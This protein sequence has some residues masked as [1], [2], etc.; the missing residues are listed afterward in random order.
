VHFA[1]DQQGMHKI[2]ARLLPVA[3]VVTGLLSVYGG[4]F[5][6]R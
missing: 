3:I 1:A 6:Q 4:F 5:G 2:N